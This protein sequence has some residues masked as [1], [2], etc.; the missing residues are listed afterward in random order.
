MLLLTLVVLLLALPLSAQ[1]SG[2]NLIGRITDGSNSAL[3]GVTVTATNSETAF[4][5]M[6]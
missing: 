5:A 4:R 3:P 6:S 1:N 2:G